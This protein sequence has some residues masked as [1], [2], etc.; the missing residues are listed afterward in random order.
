M[1]IQITGSTGSGKTTYSKKIAKE[2]NIPRYELDDIHWIRDQKGDTRRPMDEKLALLTE[3]VN[4]NNWV[5]EGV[6]F[7]WSDNSFEEADVIIVLDVS[8]LKNRYQIIKRF[9]K[10]K[11]GL[12]KSKY[13]PSLKALKNMFEWEKDY[14]TYEREQLLIKLEP[15]KDKV[16]FIKSQKD[17][18]ELIQKLIKG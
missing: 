10:Q 1:K 14:R 6:Q 3:I 18:E 7:K 16:C 13:K 12:E 9:L 8:Q 5:I 2:L 17:K 4:Q 15:Y 11:L